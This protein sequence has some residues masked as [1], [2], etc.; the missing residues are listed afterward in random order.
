MPELQLRWN[1]PKFK[2]L[3]IWFTNDLYSCDKLNYE[4]KF[5]EITFLMRIWIKRILTPLGRIAVLKSLV[6]SKLTY[7]WLLL[8]NPPDEQ[9]NRLQKFIYEFVWNRK[10]DRIS[11]KISSKGIA[12]GGIG[13][14]CVKSLMNSSK[15]TWVRRL[16]EGKQKW[17]QILR[18]VWPD[19]NTSE[20]SVRTL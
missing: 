13:I 2:I 12:N 20:K 5:Q 19:I 17:I 9:M 11:R 3:G 6:L 16:K 14:P 7:L 10:K 18:L 4:E 8:P 15:I 1:P